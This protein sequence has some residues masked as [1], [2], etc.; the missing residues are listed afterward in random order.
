MK[1][2]RGPAYRKPERAPEHRHGE[3]RD[4][5]QASLPRLHQPFSARLRRGGVPFFANTR[6]GLGRPRPAR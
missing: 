2:L 6:E 1:R 4:P 5:S 3:S